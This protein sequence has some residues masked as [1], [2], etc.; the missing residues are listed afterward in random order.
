MVVE[1][2]RPE[3]TWYIRQQVMWPDKPIDFVKL[4]DD[5]EGFH[6]GLYK[7]HVL[8]SVISCFEKGDEL[9]FRKFATLKEYQGQGLGTYLLNYILDDA[10]KRGFKRIWCNARADKKGFYEKFGLADTSKAFSKE[11][12]TFTIMELIVSRKSSG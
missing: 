2:I 3:V 4:E 11:G 5:F 9:Q 10:I 1:Q 12:V 8:T 7:D 6:Y